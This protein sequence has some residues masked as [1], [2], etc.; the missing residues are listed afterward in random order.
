[1]FSVFLMFW[2][3][4]SF[5]LGLLLAITAGSFALPI[6]QLAERFMIAGVGLFLL[7]DAFERARFRANEEGRKRTERK[8]AQSFKI[9]EGS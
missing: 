3:V 4:A 2:G 9:I 6:A 8:L 1:M 7:P 5:C